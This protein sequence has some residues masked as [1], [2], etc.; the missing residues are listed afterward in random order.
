MHTACGKEL[1]NSEMFMSKFIKD[2]DE[3]ITN[4]KLVMPAITNMIGLFMRLIYGKQSFCGKIHVQY[5]KNRKFI[6]DKQ[7]VLN[8]NNKKSICTNAERSTL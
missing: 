2:D 5:I 7:N 8:V 3:S 1:A 6:V 4:L